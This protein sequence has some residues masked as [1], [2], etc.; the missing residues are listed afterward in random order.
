MGF[1]C[2]ALGHYHNY[3]FCCIVG[4]DNRIH[5]AVQLDLQPQPT[6]LSSLRLP[7][8]RAFPNQYSPRTQHTNSPHNIQ[9]DHYAPPLPSGLPRYQLSDSLSHA[10]NLLQQSW[11]P[12]QRINLNTM[13]SLIMPNPWMYS[14]SPQYSGLMSHPG[15]LNMSSNNG[16]DETNHRQP[17]GW[18]PTV[19]TNGSNSGFD[20]VPGKQ[21][22]S[23]C[24]KL[25]SNFAM[26]I[27]PV[28]SVMLFSL[29]FYSYNKHSEIDDTLHY[30]YKKFTG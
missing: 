27:M 17:L 5:S 2:I 12:F 23:F 28:N 22:N 9:P 3:F 1:N 25:C 21:F 20:S 16:F 30:P 10:S 18:L 13:S 7:Q 19:M 11:N 6:L 24:N 8:Q 14:S 29:S 4:A 26:I 15:Q